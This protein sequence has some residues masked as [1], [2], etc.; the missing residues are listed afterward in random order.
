VSIL[1]FRTD[2]NVSMGTG[3]VMRCLALAQAW[4]DAGGDAVFAMAEATPS[5]E[6]R[7]R[8]EGAK[9]LRLQ[10][11]AG[12]ADDAAC[13][14]DNAQ[15]EGAAWVVGDGYQFGP[16][17]VPALQ[18]GGLKVLQ[19]DD[20]G[21]AGTYSAD[22]VLNQNLHACEDLYRN[23]AAH[24]RLLLG[25]RYVLLRREFAFWRKRK[26]EIKGR[27]R[28]VLLTMGGSDPDNV[29]ERVLRFLLDEP[30][31]ELTIA[32]GGSNPHLVSI[33]KMAESAAGPVRLL[34]DVSNM[35]ALMVWADL[36]VAGAGTTSWEMCMMGL[37][38]ALCV[39]APNQENIAAELARTG[40]A[41]SLG[42]IGRNGTREAASVLHE[43]IGSETKRAKMSARGRALVDGRGA[44]RA[45]AFLWGDPVLRRTVDS[46][47]QCF[48]EWAND[49]G[50]RAVSF[51]K[52]P[53][54]WERHMEWF[55]ARM[56][57]PKSIMYT[58]L[59][60]AGNAM[61]MVRYQLEGTRA[62]LSINLGVPFRG[63]GNGRRLLALATAEL[64]Q[65]S[66]ATAIDAF[67][68]LSNQPSIRLFEGAG[69]RK[70][71]TESIHGDEAIHFV[72]EK[73]VLA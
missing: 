16:E 23:R 17:Y 70:I 4:Q 65:N 9:L 46:D 47:C 19:I 45:V 26:F 6:A 5:I 42:G 43:L 12:G 61:G 50:T 1:L 56:A 14:I 66:S 29:T 3:H 67:V 73:S 37:P 15:R 10:V 68:R 60:R 53:I 36:A 38:A 30:D 21:E 34:K 28:R 32:V 24:T 59:N 51:A 63:K 52:D 35:P 20:N 22:L 44:E 58:A 49:P 41:V 33:E 39:L 62:V 31:L 2:A 25:T 11:A 54:P 72:L 18:A 55:R 57:D 48:W 7:L 40:A 8:I 69:F 13:T 27:A 71:G 64:F